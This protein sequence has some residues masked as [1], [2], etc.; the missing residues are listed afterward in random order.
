MS[1]Q[2]LSENIDELITECESVTETN[3]YWKIYEVSKLVKEH[4]IDLRDQM[5]ED[6]DEG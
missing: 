4:A 5:Q 6:T 1:T 3:C 2:N